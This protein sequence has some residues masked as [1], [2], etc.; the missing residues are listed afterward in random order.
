MLL[1]H[2]DTHHLCVVSSCLCAL[3]AELR[4]CNLDNMRSRGEMADTLPLFGLSSILTEQKDTTTRTQRPVK[5]LGKEVLRV[6]TGLYLILS[7]CHLMFT[8]G[9]A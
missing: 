6:L 2:R 8:E 3:K 7:V 5:Q 9:C 4:R 1:E